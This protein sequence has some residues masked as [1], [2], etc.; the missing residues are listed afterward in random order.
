MKEDVVLRELKRLPATYYIFKDLHLYLHQAV[1]YRKTQE[2]IDFSQIDFV[3][4]GPTGIFIIEGKEW[5]IQILNDY[6]HLP[7]KEADKAGLIF[8]I[9]MYN[10]FCKKFPIYNIAVML[11][12]VSKVKYKYIQNI[13]CFYS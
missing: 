13:S 8:Y 10:R 5:G 2:T 3:V 6:S 1:K 12:K 7:L 11:Q 4:I 9:R